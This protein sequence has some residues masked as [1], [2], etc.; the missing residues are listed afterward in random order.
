MKKDKCIYSHIK[1]DGKV[2]YIGIGSLRRAKTKS[3]RNPL[4]KNIVKNIPFYE[5]RILKKNITIDEAIE[6]EKILINWYGRRDLMTGILCNMTDGGEGVLNPSIDRKLTNTTRKFQLT[7]DQA[8]EL[9]INKNMSLSDMATFMNLGVGCIK[10]NLKRLGIKKEWV[11]RK[12]NLSKKFNRVIT[13]NASKKVIDSLTLK[14]YP[15]VASAAT[16]NGIKES[17]LRHQLLGT[18]KSKTNLKFYNE[19]NNN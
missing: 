16:E 8:I 10:K 18:Y 11:L 4:W 1:P 9:Y 2:F 6:L 14:I 15:S 7:K 5:V 3:S 12:E 17:T 19:S 13:P